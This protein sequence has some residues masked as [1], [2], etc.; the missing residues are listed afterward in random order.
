M[1][2][3][4]PVIKT[5]QFCTDGSE[6]AG[7]RNIPTIGIGP[8]RYDMAHVVDENIEIEKIVTAAK[9]Y[10]YLAKEY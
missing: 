8:G 4:E 3:I 5:Y 6:C 7:K 1:L 9:I 2:L 10:S